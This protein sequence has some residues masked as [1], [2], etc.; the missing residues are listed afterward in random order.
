M[1]IIGG[2]VQQNPFF[3]QPDEFLEDLRERRATRV[4]SLRSAL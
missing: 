4:G 1:V 3:V 2:I